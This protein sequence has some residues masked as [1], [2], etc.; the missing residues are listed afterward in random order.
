MGIE[1]LV[2]AYSHLHN[3]GEYITQAKL[4]EAEGLTSESIL[5]EIKDGLA[6]P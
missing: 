2:I 5:G 4:Y 6:P 3:I 1:R